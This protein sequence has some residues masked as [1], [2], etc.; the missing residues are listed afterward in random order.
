MNHAILL[1]WSV[2]RS[3]SKYFGGYIWTILISNPKSPSIATT[4]TRS[5][6]LTQYSYTYKEN[7]VPIRNVKLLLMPIAA[8]THKAY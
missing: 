6:F 4:S 1:Y 2:T 5:F 8:D 3:E 7:G